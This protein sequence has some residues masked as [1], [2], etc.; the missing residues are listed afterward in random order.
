MMTPVT[1]VNENAATAT[2]RAQCMDETKP[3]SDSESLIRLAAGSLQLLLAPE[4]GGSVTALYDEHGG[5]RFHWLRPATS[6]AM[7]R[8]DLFAMASFPLLPWCN[9]IRDGRAHFGDRDIA[10]APSHPAPPSGKHALHGIGWMRPW[11]VADA[12]ATAATLVLSVEADA[13]WPW[14][15]DA[16]QSFELD[17]DGLRC[18]ITLTNRDTAPMPGGIGHH[19]YFPHREG[20][21]LQT[22][23]A[24][25]W[26]GDAEVMPVALEAGPEVA[27]LREGV[28]LADLDLDNN[29]TGW[30][31]QARIEWPGSSRSLVMG[32]ES[33]L[34]FFVLYC[35]RGSDHFCA[36]PVSQC[37]DA[38]N[39][40]GGHGPD[41]VGGAVLAPGETLTGCWTVRAA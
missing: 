23:T 41:E 17:P 15:F 20:T 24:A 10:I 39:L 16:S 2:I 22:G 29:F 12:S 13:Q 6:E 4:I 11:R 40:W 26:L 38:I 28:R 30:G 3:A 7:V 33:P 5:E 31:H 35:P 14:R 21:R 34:D 9:R 36:E 8:R 25:M 27:R 18:T 1:R 19:P 37:T 32:A